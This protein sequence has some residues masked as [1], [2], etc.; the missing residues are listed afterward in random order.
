[1]QPAS[2]AVPKEE[3]VTCAACE[4]EFD[5]NMPERMRLFQHLHRQEQ[6]HIWDTCA[7][8]LEYFEDY[9][10]ADLY[11]T[12]WKDEPSET[13]FC[14][15]ECEHAYL[16][17]GDFQY[18]DCEAC[19]RMVCQQNPAN[20]WMC[21]FREHA[22]LGDICLRCY[23]TEILKNGQPRSDFEDAQIKGGMFFNGGN[24][25]PKAKGFDTVDGFDHFYVT[26]ADT[27]RR[28]NSRA[29]ELI[30]RRHKVLTAYES[31]GIGGS[32]GFITM[33]AKR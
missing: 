31:L 24:P 22:D 9:P 21:Q 6:L 15:E 10:V 27:A 17:A 2:V 25:E 12:P 30:D 26:G 4:A 18:R 32:E 28:Y 13:H 14:S 33:M 23:E 3:I 16:Y 1:M 8:L 11:P 5:A 19:G 7:F 29:L 20:G